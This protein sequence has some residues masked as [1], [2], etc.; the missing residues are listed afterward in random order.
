MAQVASTLDVPQSH[1]ATKSKAT[2]II[3]QGFGWSKKA[4]Q[5]A[6]VEDGATKAFGWNVVFSEMSG[7]AKWDNTT[8]TQFQWLSYKDSTDAVAIDNPPGVFNRRT[9]DAILVRGG[10]CSHGASMPINL[11]NNI[12]VDRS[13]ENIAEKLANVKIAL[14]ALGG[15]LNDSQTM[16]MVSVDYATV[17]YDN[18][19]YGKLVDVSDNYCN[20]SNTV[21]GLRVRVTSVSARDTDPL[22]NDLLNLKKLPDGLRAIPVDD[23]KPKVIEVL[24]PVPLYELPD[25]A[26]I[27]RRGEVI[28]SALSPTITKGPKIN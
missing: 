20:S 26:E 2:A 28:N 22:K 13:Q 15:E 5:T 12:A 17:P 18:R 11:I 10:F 23:S 25:L 19:V 3:A 8:S 16:T 24:P 4:V 21:D 7:T 14:Q 1:L 9:A 6:L 27:M